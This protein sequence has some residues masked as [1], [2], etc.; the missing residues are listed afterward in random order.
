MAKQR[1]QYRLKKKGEHSFLT[2]DRIEKLENC[3]FAWQVRSSAG[4]DAQNSPATTSNAARQR[5]SRTVYE[6]HDP[7]DHVVGTHN[8]VPP[9]QLQVM[10]H[11]TINMLAQNDNDNDDDD[12]VADETA[13]QHAVGDIVEC[14]VDKL[15]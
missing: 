11:P 2:D 8:V 4:Y 3:G 10:Q 5:P 1:E 15:M 7:Q 9:M 12:I 13:L 14:L 6:T